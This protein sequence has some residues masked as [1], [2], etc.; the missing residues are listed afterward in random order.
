MTDSGSQE[1]DSAREL[2]EEYLVG[3]WAQALRLDSVG[4][5]D[6]FFEEGGDSLAAMQVAAEVAD[7]FQLELSTVM[8][9]NQ[10]TV[11]ELA[12]SVEKALEERVEQLS[13]DELEEGLTNAGSGVAG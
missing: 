3:L 12:A 13:D 11:R 2:L 7:R 10:P 9:F 1:T 5:D 8:A 6:D 4:L